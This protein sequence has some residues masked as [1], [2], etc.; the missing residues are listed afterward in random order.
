MQTMRPV[1]RRYLLPTLAAASLMIA[2]ARNHVKPPE[3]KTLNLVR[4]TAALLV[5]LAHRVGRRVQAGGCH[6]GIERDPLVALVLLLP[7]KTV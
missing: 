4:A 3:P 6:R 5:Y 1:P 2:R 7:L